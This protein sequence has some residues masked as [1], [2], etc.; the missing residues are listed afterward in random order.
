MIW[1]TSAL[2]AA[3]PDMT[4]GVEG[5]ILPG[6]CIEDLCG[7]VAKPA[8]AGDVK[9]QQAVVAFVQRQ[10]C[11]YRPGVGIGEWRAVAEEIG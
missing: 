6:E 1:R 3:P 2:L 9:P 4:M 7:A 5:S 11:E 10:A 8:K